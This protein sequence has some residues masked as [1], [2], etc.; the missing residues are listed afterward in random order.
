[1]KISL[2]DLRT[3]YL[4]LGADRVRFAH[5]YS[6]TDEQAQLLATGEA[7]DAIEELPGR[8]AVSLAKGALA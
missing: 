6:I 2:H 5:T 1:M 4:T 8:C 7:F 3:E